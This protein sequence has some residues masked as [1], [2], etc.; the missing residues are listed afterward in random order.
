MPLCDIM[1]WTLCCTVLCCCVLFMYHHSKYVCMC[2]RRLECYVRWDDRT[3]GNNNKK[4]R[5]KKE[6]RRITAVLCI[7]VQEEG[8]FCI[9]RTTTVVEQIKIYIHINNLTTQKR[10]TR[11]YKQVYLNNVCK[12]IINWKKV[13]LQ[14]LFSVHL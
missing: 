8:N 13:L 7:H 12:K 4:A 9:T 10:K 14:D 2:T 3:I 1:N 6:R 5:R 11:K